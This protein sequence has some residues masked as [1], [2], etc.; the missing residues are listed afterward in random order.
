MRIHEV[1]PPGRE[2]Q[3]KKLKKKFDDPSA[4]YAI[5]WAQHNKHGKPK[6]ETKYANVPGREY[7]ADDRAEAKLWS[8]QDRKSALLKKLDRVAG[9][10]GKVNI[11][12][13][14][15]KELQAVKKAIG[16]LKKQGIGEDRIPT[17]MPGM[18]GDS[19]WY[20][21][22]GQLVRIV[23]YTQDGKDGIYT[24]SFG[25]GRGE[26][27]V[28]VHDLEFI[29]DTTYQDLPDYGDTE[30]N[31]SDIEADADTLASA[32]MGSDE[33]Y[34]YYGDNESVDPIRS[35][36]GAKE[37][38]A[39]EIY[40]NGSSAKHYQKMYPTWEDFMNSEDF[41]EENMRLWNK[42]GESK[43]VEMCPEACC[44]VPVTECSCGSDCKHCDCN[45]KNNEVKEDLKK[46]LN[47]RMPASVI[48]HKQKLSFMTDK[49]LADRF[50]D[51]DETRLRQM[52]WRHGYGKMSSHYW[53]RV[54]AGKNES[55]TNEDQT[56]VDVKAILDKHGIKSTYDIEYG[57]DA[58]SDL[59]D[60]FSSDPDEMPYG[61]QK[62]RTG[63]P[64]EWIA[65]RLIDLGLLKEAPFRRRFATK[66]KNPFSGTQK[67][68]NTLGSMFGSRKAQ[69]RLN[70]GVEANKIAKDWEDY[71]SGDTARQI[72]KNFNGFLG[73]IGGSGNPETS[74][75]WFQKNHKIT[76]PPADYQ[77][78]FKQDGT[79][80]ERDTVFNII[81]K[82]SLDS[83]SIQTWFKNNHGMVLTQ[84]DV[85]QL[86]ANPKTAII[87][88]VKRKEAGQMGPKADATK[89]ETKP[90]AQG[91][92]FTG[93]DQAD[94]TLAQIK[95]LNPDASQKSV[96]ALDK[97]KPDAQGK[98]APLNPE[99]EKELAP[100]LQKI[101]AALT[102]PAKRAKLVNMMT[103]GKYSD[104]KDFTSI[105]SESISREELSKLDYLARQ[106]LVPSSKVSRFKTAMR[107]LAKG[108]D[109]SIT[110]K[111]DVVDVV[112]KLAGII[113]KPGVMQ[114]VRRGLNKDKGKGK[115]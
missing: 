56:T 11:N 88:F 3:V 104:F 7:D 8:L 35:D 12:D 6:K 94:P 106:G 26:M 32:G 18:V 96:K 68:L 113:T 111:N 4:A 44:G 17:D 108:K 21:K 24:I 81:K 25:D 1:A 76:I 31:M 30:D 36:R 102:D 5:A 89:P 79:P 53:D 98:M 85:N 101:G 38:L 110:Y 14:I 86:L 15:Y 63:M 77:K 112:V 71:T 103:S 64:D 27:D 62:A 10:G 61:V 80:Q 16:N 66:S 84:P 42:F 45:A 49:E 92:L 74:A 39:K 2:K 115:K 58:F 107:T 13:P 54:Q 40:Y 43:N 91:D 97:L 50:K 109:L 83:D 51:F 57:S 72:N 70:T 46:S 60:Y 48:K 23:D 87:D 55:V 41:E 69:G 9:E 28:L 47:E 93:D 52:A 67:A 29:D 75:K 59:F 22:T 95:K 33:D 37:E 99:E 20:K 73:S 65:N 34:G 100:I 78:T 19:A 90:D 105:L 114:M 82:S